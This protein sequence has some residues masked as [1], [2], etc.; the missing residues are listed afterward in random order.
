LATSGESTVPELVIINKNLSNDKMVKGLI[1]KVSRSVSATAYWFDKLYE[2]PLHKAAVVL[3]CCQ[4]DALSGFNECIESIVTSLMERQG[5]LLPLGESPEGIAELEP[6]ITYEYF[7]TSLVE[8][9]S[10]YANRSYLIFDNRKNPLGRWSVVCCGFPEKSHYYSGSYEVLEP[11]PRELT[12]I[13]ILGQLL[14]ADIAGWLY[15]NERYSLILKKLGGSNDVTELKMGQ[16]T[17]KYDVCDEN[18][19]MPKM[20][21]K[22]HQ[23]IEARINDSGSNVSSAIYQSKNFKNSI[24]LTEISL[25]EFTTENNIQKLELINQVN[26]Y[27]SEDCQGYSYHSVLGIEETVYRIAMKERQVNP[28]VLAGNIFETNK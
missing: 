20:I 17:N 19:R 15:K 24:F 11:S 7:I 22:L 21:E 3:Q 4:D 28:S 23:W 9:L 27:Q 2:R 14:D 26:T 18:D 10:D 13:F 16:K 6:V 12:K 5:K 8:K 1:K 25:L